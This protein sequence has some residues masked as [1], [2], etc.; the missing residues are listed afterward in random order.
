M[1]W[2]NLDYPLLMS[3]FLLI[4]LIWHCLE[5]IIEQII[6]YD[7]IKNNIINAYEDKQSH[8]SLLTTI[9]SFQDMD[10][11]STTL[12][13][14]HVNIV[15]DTIMD[16]LKIH[17]G[18]DRC[19]VVSTLGSGRA[20]IHK[21]KYIEFISDPFIM[22]EIN[23][24]NKYKLL[25]HF[26]Q[27]E[28]LVGLTWL[29]SKVFNN[30]DSGQINIYDKYYSVYNEL[31]ALYTLF[32]ID[33]DDNDKHEY[34]ANISDILI[35]FIINNPEFGLLNITDSMILVSCINRCIN[36]TE[37]FIINTN[38]YL[39][40][41]A[42]LDMEEFYKHTL[43]NDKF[44]N[45]NSILRD[46]YEHVSILNIIKSITN[47][48]SN[49]IINALSST[50]PKFDIN[51]TEIKILL[52]YL[53]EYGMLETTTAHNRLIDV[54]S[55][56]IDGI[57]NRIKN[58]R[59]NALISKLTLL[60]TNNYNKLKSSTNESI[61]PVEKSSTT[62]FTSVRKLRDMINKRI[63]ERNVLIETRGNKTKYSKKNDDLDDLQ[64]QNTDEE[65]LLQN[66]N[67]TLPTTD[68]II[69]AIKPSKRKLSLVKSIISIFKKS[70]QNEQ[71]K[72]A[73]KNT[74][75]MI[76]TINTT[77][78]QLIEPELQ[79]PMQG[80][81]QESAMI[82]PMVQP[83]QQ[84]MINLY[85]D[86]VLDE[87]NTTNL[88]TIFTFSQNVNDMTDD[89]QE[90]SD[91]MES[92]ANELLTILDNQSDEVEK[93]IET[94][95]SSNADQQII[96]KMA[97][98]IDQTIEYA[99]VETIQPSNMLDEFIQKQEIIT[100]LME[101]IGTRYNRV[102][103]ENVSL[104][105]IQSNDSINETNAR[106]DS[107]YTTMNNHV[108][109]LNVAID[110]TK[111]GNVSNEL[112]I[113]NKQN[114]DR[115]VQNINSTNEELVGEFDRLLELKQQWKVKELERIS[116]E[117]AIKIISNAP[118]NELTPAIVHD[119]I[120]QGEIMSVSK[121]YEMNI[122]AMKLQ[123]SIQNM[124]LEERNSRIIETEKR[125]RDAEQK[126]QDAV[127][128][129]AISNEMTNEMLNLRKQLDESRVTNVALESQK[130]SLDAQ[131]NHVQSDIDDLK[132][133]LD[134]GVSAIMQCPVIADSVTNSKNELI[135]DIDTHK[136]IY[137]GT[138]RDINTRVNALILEQQQTM[139]NTYKM[140]LQQQ[141]DLHQQKIMEVQNEFNNGIKTSIMEFK[142][143]LI[144]SIGDIKDISINENSSLSE[145]MNNIAKFIEQNNDKVV[146][147]SQR[148][149]DLENH[150]EEL[151]S[152]R[153]DLNDQLEQTKKI[154][155]SNKQE[156]ESA[157]QILQSDYQNVQ[158]E[159]TQ[160][161]TKLDTAQ[162]QLQQVQQQLDNNIAPLQVSN[163]ALS[164]QRDNLLETI[165]TIKSSNQALEL[166]IRDLENEKGA[167]TGKQDLD[168]RIEEVSRLSISLQEM[169][170][171]YD[172][173]VQEYAQIKNKLTEITNNNKQLEK[174]LNEQRE[175]FAMTTAKDHEDNRRNIAYC[176]GIGGEY[177]NKKMEML[178]KLYDVVNHNGD[179][180]TNA[181]KLTRDLVNAMDIFVVAILNQEPHLIASS[182]PILGKIYSL[183]PKLVFKSPNEGIAPG[184]IDFEML[185]II[186]SI[187]NTI[188]DTHYKMLSDISTCGIDISNVEKFND[189]IYSM[190]NFVDNC[191]MLFDGYDANNQDYDL[192]IFSYIKNDANIKDEF[193][194]VALLFSKQYGK[195]VYDI[196]DSHK[197]IAFNRLHVIF[198]IFGFG[199][200]QH[201]QALNDP[202]NEL[203]PEFQR[204]V[205]NFNKNIKLT[206]S[207]RIQKHSKPTPPDELTQ[208]QSIRVPR[209][210]INDAA[211]EQLL[212]NATEEKQRQRKER[213][214]ASALDQIRQNIS[215]T[216]HPI[217]ETGYD[218]TLHPDLPFTR[219]HQPEIV[220]DEDENDM[221]TM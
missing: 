155:E 160:L 34:L 186:Y 29:S 220:I 8:N 168:S 19:L 140:E 194:K 141:V 89:T 98:M 78:D 9:E 205:K 101:D 190:N 99:A 135:D 159:K 47:V 108:T 172:T 169:K 53:K 200:M 197:S 216:M 66:I 218:D 13:S 95:I 84:P 41:H 72:D 147:L 23:L 22:Q 59:N 166:R 103:Y 152:A 182:D 42:T 31:R 187:Y 203:Y 199:S 183:K 137:S 67:E 153:V 32:I 18:G 93:I 123:Q 77:P 27:T 106:I 55:K 62:I 219:S 15:F 173:E 33:S 129:S 38:K 94:D 79:Q 132:S 17:T 209:V 10:S 68:D 113:K 148:I 6:E 2:I 65:K 185:S 88:D 217:F 164:A 1:K 11:S 154:Y 76:T 39:I 136:R 221:R 70:K 213:E 138:L 118:I 167:D 61:K 175:I 206:P 107:L 26:N 54:M 110:D 193:K 171:K 109:E 75:D 86:I 92:S 133:H 63:N 157:K 177:K 58:L 35:T 130:I 161:Q 158:T 174:Q 51:I 104:A 85:P 73:I 125:L 57:V 14:N 36:G 56:N 80:P 43:E 149:Q 191:R 112:S 142:I 139:D 74:T 4:H 204:W 151:S 179:P 170:D 192:S 37:N 115:I 181:P 122:D 163:Q 143:K 12:V 45:I 214:D 25:K 195:Y 146:R 114:I 180:I 156:W 134:L 188:V 5:S 201:Y 30:I 196:D 127:A 121:E 124:E 202:N 40:D 131:L 60:N 210:M 7:I 97:E 91:K 28:K 117:Q 207:E 64:E 50:N 120:S 96:N 162:K 16:I 87:S 46:T 189:N 116:N 111:L 145:C 102:Q 3:L 211:V 48:K 126:L 105:N 128:A 184:T 82:Q 49:V 165:S 81:M 178:Y 198:S 212:Q 20:L 71:H 52:P 208:D 83:M 215:N 69:S 90:L 24:Y 150:E 119:V 100:K 176:L 144:N 44:V 21:N